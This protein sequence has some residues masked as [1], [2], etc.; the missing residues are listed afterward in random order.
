MRIT[1]RAKPGSS[2]TAVGGSHDG[3]LIVR[4]NAPAVDGRATTAVLK[5][6]AEAFGLSTS[7]VT[8]HSGH[9]SRT[10]ILMLD[11]D[12]TELSARLAELLAR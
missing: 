4:V 3:A 1:V 11:A 9:S 8:I 5:A 10:K 12:E 6:V 2:R 7:Q